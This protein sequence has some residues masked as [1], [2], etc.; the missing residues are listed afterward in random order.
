MALGASPLRSVGRLVTVFCV[1]SAVG[2]LVGA[3]AAFAALQIT[4]SLFGLSA[5][6]IA[7]GLLMGSAIAG[8]AALGALLGPLQE[9]LTNSPADLLRE[10]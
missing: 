9:A 8:I 6:S 3:L 1:N 5:G 10:T 4:R 2:V 7:F